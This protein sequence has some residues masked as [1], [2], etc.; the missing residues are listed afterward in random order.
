MFQTIKDIIS[1]IKNRERLWLS[2]GFV[3]ATMKT[4]KANSTKGKKGPH[5]LYG[6][7][8]KK[9]VELKE[10]LEMYSGD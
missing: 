5:Y 7:I 3:D 6:K 4:I 2:A 1:T 10:Y 8:G 9:V